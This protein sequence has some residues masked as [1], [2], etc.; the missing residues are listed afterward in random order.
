M[1]GKE[2]NQERNIGLKV[3]AKI[4][5]LNLEH[6]NC[7]TSNKN[8]RLYLEDNMMKNLQKAQTLTLAYTLS[9]LLKLKRQIIKA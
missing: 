8:Q 4:G 3:G 7:Q 1:L 5:P 6:S 9:I 2:R